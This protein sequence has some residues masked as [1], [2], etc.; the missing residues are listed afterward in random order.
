[1]NSKHRLFMRS[2]LDSFDYF[3]FGE[4]DMIL[5]VDQTAAIM[6]ENDR[7]KDLFPKEHLNFL[8][9]LLRYSVILPSPAACCL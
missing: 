9:G 6:R 1:M 5:G 3:V 7:L 2:H 8:V 4:E